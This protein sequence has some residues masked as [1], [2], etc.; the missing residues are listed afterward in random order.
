M[1][2]HPGTMTCFECLLKPLK[3]ML[4]FMDLDRVGSAPIQGVRISSRSFDGKARR[5]F[6]QVL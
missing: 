1:G 5:S 4:A 2:R 3:K 6:L